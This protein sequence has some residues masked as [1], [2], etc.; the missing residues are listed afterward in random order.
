ML[1]EIIPGVHKI[2][3]VS[4][5]NCY[6]ITYGPEL[7]LIDTGMRGSSKKIEKYLNGLEKNLSDIKYIIITHADPDHIGGAMEMRMLTGAKVVIHAGEMPALAGDSSSRLRN[8]SRIVKILSV[9]L[10][11]LI[12]FPLVR[13]DIV[14]EENTEIAGFKIVNTPGHSDGSI[15]IY[16]PGKVIF[17][18]DALTSD[19]KGNLRQP[20]KALAADMVQAKETVKMITEL[21]F[22]TLLVGHGAP[23]KGDAVNKVKKLLENWK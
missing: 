1:M 18:G 4:G 19:A 11:G 20:M 22:D 14:L 7:V 23:V 6:L 21:E 3:C 10:S 9:I 8:K 15:S 12:R 17:V 5:A 13:P 2:D 16:Q